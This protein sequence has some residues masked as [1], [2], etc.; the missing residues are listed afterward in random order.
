MNFDQN[1]FNWLWG[2]IDKH[3][4]GSWG[5]AAGWVFFGLV[6]HMSSDWAVIFKIAKIQELVGGFFGLIFLFLSVVITVLILRRFWQI[7]V[8]AFRQFFKNRSIEIEELSDL[9]LALL[10][11]INETKQV[12]EFEADSVPIKYLTQYGLIE[13]PWPRAIMSSDH[14]TYRVTPQGEYLLK[15]NG[16]V[17]AERLVDADRTWNLVWPFVYVP[18]KY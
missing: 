2:L 10:V 1:G 13:R 4:K 14:L 3:L 8:Q 7:S 9:E 17:I 18:S 5:L 6:A 15:K 12:H 11:T 16:D